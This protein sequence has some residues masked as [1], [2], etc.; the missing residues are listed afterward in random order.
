MAVRFDPV[1]RRRAYEEVA[2]RL[3]QAILAGEVRPGERLP[4]ER[5]LTSQFAVSRATVREALR[6][7]EIDGLVES[8]PND[9]HGGT[10]VCSP[11]SVAVS[12]SLLSYM[13]F[14]RLSLRE[15]VEFRMFVESATAFLAASHRSEVQL[16]AIARAHAELGAKV[17]EDSAAFSAADA[18]FH[19]AIADA[20]GNRILRICSETANAAVQQLIGQKLSASVDPSTVMRDW[21]ERHGRILAA[22]ERRDPLEAYRLASTDICEYYA[23][24]LPPEDAHR[25]AT[26]IG[27][28]L[29]Q[30]G[31]SAPA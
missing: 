15:V 18:A 20:A 19:E 10:I 25:V 5:Q 30:L 4:S 29:P 9:P 3:E 12:R 16:A 24:Y 28:A 17:G 26:L 21:V 2:H 1:P 8:R 27:S 13:R 31:L 6:S 11:S 7:L 14:D 23:E 22:I